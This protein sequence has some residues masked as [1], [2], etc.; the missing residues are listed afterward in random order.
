MQDAGDRRSN[1][2]S[3]YSIVVCDDVC[4]TAEYIVARVR[5]KMAELHCQSNVVW[6][7]DSRKL[8][9]S[10]ENGNYYDV[11]LMDIDMPGTNGIDLC[12]L[13]RQKGNESIIVFVSAKEQ[14]VFQTFEVQPFRFIRKTFFEEEL[15]GLCRDLV[16]E[17]EKRNEKWLRF[18]N[19]IEDKV[20]AVNINKLIYVEA[21]N[22]ECCLV[23][24]NEEQNIKIKLGDLEE[25]LASYSF[26]K[27]HRSYL[28]NP[29]HI[30]KIDQDEV[31]LTGDR[32]IPLS[33]RRRELIKEMYF[34]W[35]TKL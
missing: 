33:R 6:Y 16:R 12:K 1:G 4:E 8:K 23:S 13:C 9:K 30:F 11:M 14:M 27:V 21:R 15:D 34:N 10:I 3:M 25:S 2:G 5:D 31:K 35:S 18:Y 24:T 22:K 20:Y 28:V 17:L 29:M 7:S 19:E 32:T 26:I